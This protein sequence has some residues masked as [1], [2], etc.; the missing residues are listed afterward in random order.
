MRAVQ[1]FPKTPTFHYLFSYRMFEKLT[2][3]ACAAVTL[4]LFTACISGTHSLDGPQS[5]AEVRFKAVAETRAS[6]T[7][8]E[9]I[10]NRHFAVYGDMKPLA[11]SAAASPNIIFNGTEV[12][13]D[14]TSWKYANL[15]YWYPDHEHSFVAL[16]PAAEANISELTYNTTLS[17]KYTLPSADPATAYKGIG[18]LLT[19]THRRIYT[20]GNSHAVAFNFGHIMARLN[21]VAKIDP[22]L[23]TGNSVT[24]QKLALR[25]I[26]NSATYS[27]TP[28]PVSS[29]ETDDYTGGTWSGF[30]EP[31]AVLFDISPEGGIVLSAGDTYGFFPA[32]SDPLLVIPQE[33]NENL[34][35]EITYKRHINGTDEASETAVSKL[36]STAVSSHGGVWRPGKSYSY[37]FSIGVD[38]LIIFSVPNIQ[39]WSESEGG[40]YIISQ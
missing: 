36:F 13:H 38:D 35:I 6:L 4:S 15:Q 18:D 9:T 16:H 20:E 33:V 22:A 19:A 5:S 40:N 7:N 28:A 12:T 10:K 2:Y 30:S 21:F 23:G 39:D 3:S 1:T 31:A 29:G 8:N 24:I 27:I 14:G 37:S 25:N 26:S 17:F 11:A 32:D 34:E